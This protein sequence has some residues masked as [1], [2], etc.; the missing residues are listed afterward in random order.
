MKITQAKLHGHFERNSW[1]MP[2]MIAIFATPFM[3]ISITTRNAN[4]ENIS[5]LV[6]L[7]LALALLGYNLLIRSLRKKFNNSSPKR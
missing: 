5:K 3:I 2:V 4:L 6:W 1:Y 7:F